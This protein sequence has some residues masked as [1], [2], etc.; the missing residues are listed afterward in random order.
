MTHLRYSKYKNS[1]IDWIGDIPE[2]WKVDRIKASVKSCTNGIWGSEPTGDINDI[3]CVRVADFNRHNFS[4]DI[5]NP[6][7]R[8]ISQK[9]RIGRTLTKGDLLLEKSGGGEN[10]PVGCVVLYDHD[11][12]AVCSNFIAKMTLKDGMVPSF[13]KYLHSAAYSIRLTIGSINQTS[14]IQ[15]LDQDRYFEEKVAFPS[16]EEQRLIANFLDHET[17]KI[18]TLIQKQDKLIAL[19]EEKIASVTDRFVTKGLD[20]SAT[21]KKTEF[22]TL[23]EV[24]SHWDVLKI[25]KIVS[26]PVTDGPHE[27]PNFIDEGVPFVSA[28]AVSKGFIDFTKIR[29]YISHEA[30]V[31]YS[32]KYSPK[33][34]DIYMVKS[35]ATTGVTAIVEDNTDFNIWSPLAVIRC[36][37][38]MNPYYVLYAMRSKYFQ[39]MVSLSWSFGTQ[40]N[41]GMGVI[42]NLYLPIPPKHEQDAIVLKINSA[43]KKL[44]QLKEQ[45]A[46]G[47]NLLKE[48]RASLISAA[49]TGKIDVRE[50]A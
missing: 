47:I 3:I 6:T 2:D 43:L 42:E 46:K 19:I 4:V 18:D 23:G 12:Q 36:S 35:G 10:Q 27:T 32:K 22:P 28:E 20:K 44:T 7:I 15:N 26:S 9:E 40:Q 1:G 21:F 31:M 17:S 24:P 48:H 34:H 25:K 5:E 41:I 37:S 38:R 33:L 49:V 14:G 50:L 30:N 13:W 29:G 11:S 8:N 16:V 45:S 39:E